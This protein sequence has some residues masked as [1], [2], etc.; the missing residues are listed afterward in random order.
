MRCSEWV[1]GV[2]YIIYRG[3]LGSGNADKEY[4]PLDARNFIN[5]ML[6]SSAAIFAVGFLRFEMCV[7]VVVKM[8]IGLKKLLLPSFTFGLDRKK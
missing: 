3:L 8:S 1:K 2:A 7:W 6:F 5:G 4:V